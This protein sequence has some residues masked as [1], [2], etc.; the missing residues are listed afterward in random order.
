MRHPR[1]A[2]LIALTF[3][4]GAS[5]CG[6]LLGI[7]DLPGLDGGADAAADSG[8]ADA[9][10]LGSDEASVVAAPEPVESAA[11]AVEAEAG[12]VDVGAPSVP[13]CDYC[14]LVSAMAHCGVTDAAAC[15]KQVECGISCTWLD[16]VTICC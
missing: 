16:L 10:T 15:G 11:S 5:A 9:G 3:C 6:S 14:T 7:G 12:E 2:A 4:L 1:L 13:R 8:G